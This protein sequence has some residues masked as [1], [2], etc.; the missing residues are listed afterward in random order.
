MHWAQ[1]ILFCGCLI[2]AAVDD[3]RTRTVSNIVCIVIALAGLITISPA[4][5]LG[6]LL[7]MLPFYLC[8]GFGL[9]GGGDWRLAA[10]VGF[11]LGVGR[12]LTGFLFMSVALLLASLVMRAFPALRQRSSRWCHISQWLLFPHIFY[13][14]ENDLKIFRNRTVIGVLCIL[15]ALIICFGV[16]PLFSRSASEKTEIVRVTKDIKEGDE[17]TA[18]M[19]QTVEV[20]AYNL[21]QNLMTD[22]KEVVG[23]YAT[24]DLAAGDYI[25]SSKLSA[26]PA[27]ENAYLYNLDGKKQAISVTIKSFATGL[28]GKLES[29]D[30]VTVI[31]AD[32]QGKGETAIPPELQY[33]EV[34]SVTASSGY[35]ANTGEVVDEKELPSTVTLLVT[36]E[37]AKVLAE[38]EQDSE[39][40]L[41]LVYRGTPENAAKFI[42]AQDALIEELY[43]EP[44]PENSGETAEGTESKESEG[45]EPSAESEA[46]E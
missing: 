22:K 46:T 9:M 36:T 40:H 33:V 29:G 27:A 35:D 26:V 25:L 17:I 8:A 7:A 16:T 31:V 12:V 30:I 37:Q 45:A 18:E 3:L 34:I 4:S 43:A 28:S 13:K 39:L 6:A 19:V 5:L 44:E 23:K 14:E 38:L 20:G 11:V 2:Y 24:A 32:Y 21:P 10:A 15:L 41:A 42:A 1:A